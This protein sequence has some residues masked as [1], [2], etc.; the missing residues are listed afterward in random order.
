MSIFPVYVETM[1]PISGFQSMY[2]K[3]HPIILL[4]CMFLGIGKNL[5][6]ILSKISYSS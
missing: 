5:D 3:N 2:K 1:I 6:G 4:Y